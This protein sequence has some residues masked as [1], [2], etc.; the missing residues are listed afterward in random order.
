[1]YKRFDKIIKQSKF[2]IDFYE[3][4]TKND[5]LSSYI[6]GCQVILLTFDLN[7]RNSFDSLNEYWF[8]FIRND[9]AYQNIIYILGNYTNIS[10]A[11]LTSKDEIEEMI[12]IS[13]VN[14]SYIEIG[15]K[16]KDEL[17]VLIDELIVH[18]YKDDLKSGKVEDCKGGSFKVDKCIIF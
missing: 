17:N 13:Q 3:F 12:K 15:N 7:N 6:L 8:N 14:A 1:M 10:S 16:T 5:K 2:T 4:N 11:P 18:T 9:C